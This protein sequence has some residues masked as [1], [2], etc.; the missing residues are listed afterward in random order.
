MSKKKKVLFPLAILIIIAP[1]MC[2]I[3]MA[4]P[5]SDDIIWPVAGT[6]LFVDAVNNATNIYYTWGGGW[7]WNLLQCLLNPLN[8]S[9]LGSYFM[10][11]EMNVF[12]ILLIGS[13]LFMAKQIAG[14]FDKDNWNLYAFFSI[15]VLIAI[16]NGGYSNPIFTWFIGGAY[17][18]VMTSFCLYIGVMIKILLSQKARIIDIV[19]VIVLSLLTGNALNYAGSACIVWFV[20]WMYAR[21]TQK[22]SVFYLIPLVVVF[23]TALFSAFAPGNFIRHEAIG[24][25]LSLVKALVYACINL[26]WRGSCLLL[27]PAVVISIL[28]IVAAGRFCTKAEK[29]LFHPGYSLIVV[30]LCDLSMLFPMAYGYGGVG[31][32]DRMIWIFN[33]LSILLLSV[34]ALNLGIWIKEKNALQMIQ[35]SSCLGII[36]MLFLC[37]GISSPYKDQITDLRSTAKCRQEWMSVFNRV[38]KADEGTIVVNVSDMSLLK[39]KNIRTPRLVGTKVADRYVIYFGKEDSEIVLQ[40]VYDNQEVDG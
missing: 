9:K 1:F 20:T 11:V 10:G 29:H 17:G 7:F 40:Q 18:W 21:K 35:K 26:V 33:T 23:V 25:D 16:L 28:L 2:N 36:L 27:T 3:L 4:F 24:T 34:W 5:T 22:K 39:C 32:P 31:I 30:L 38:K 14:M 6:N 13:V 8:F 19:V 37:I 12:F 15:L